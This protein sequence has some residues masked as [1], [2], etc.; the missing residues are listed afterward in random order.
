M[1]GHGKL[2]MEMS[3]DVTPWTDAHTPVV[4]PW[5]RRR[6]AGV[7]A[8]LHGVDQV[9]ERAGAGADDDVV[10][11]RAF[12][13]CHEQDAVRLRVLET[14]ADVRLTPSSQALDRVVGRSTGFL[15]QGV[16]RLEVPLAYGEDQRVLVGEVQIDGWW[17]HAHGIGDRAD[18][19]RLRTSR[20]DH[21]ALRGGEEVGTQCFA[22]P[23]A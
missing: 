8:A 10:L 7:D 22:L 15:D 5:G 17:C 9:L 3:S 2:G 12:R 20:L 1:S 19:H 6:N 13:A 14:E 16:E 23:A 4:R 11:P 21:Q 18:R